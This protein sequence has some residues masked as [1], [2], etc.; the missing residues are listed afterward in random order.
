MP[1]DLDNHLISMSR[2]RVHNGHEIA[3][4]RFRGS[5]RKP[6][7]DAFRQRLEESGRR[8]SHLLVDLSE[9]EY[10]CSSGLGL[11]LEQSA[12]QERQGGWLRL[13]AP[14]RSVAMILGLSGAAQSLVWFTAED[15]ALDDLRGQ[16]A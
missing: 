7:E 16:A 11:L 13:V 3:C 4:V 10:L 9:V 12:V 14:S 15:E 1:R 5:V 8:A 2:V 6:T